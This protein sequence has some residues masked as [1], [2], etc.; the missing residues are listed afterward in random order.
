[1]LLILTAFLN[2]H[3]VLI[4]AHMLVHLYIVVYFWQPKLAQILISTISKGEKTKF[5]EF[6]ISKVSKVNFLYSFQP[7]KIVKMKCTDS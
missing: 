5:D 6:Y 4:L 7:S 2:M 1:M 3:K